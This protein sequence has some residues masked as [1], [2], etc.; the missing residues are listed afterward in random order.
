MGAPVLKKNDQSKIHSPIKNGWRIF[1]SPKDRF[2][3]FKSA[4][5]DCQIELAEKRPYHTEL[6][7]H[8]ILLLAPTALQLWQK[9]HTLKPIF[10]IFFKQLLLW[11]AYALFSDSWQ[12][13]DLLEQINNRKTNVF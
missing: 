2:D 1:C 3:L 7:Y 6:S 10:I 9:K 5:A 8:E 11:Q 13:Y 12:R 4:K